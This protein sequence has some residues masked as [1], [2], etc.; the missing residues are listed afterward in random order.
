MTPEQK[1][2]AR[3]LNAAGISQA[4]ISRRL[5][6]SRRQVRSV[7]DQS[8]RFKKPPWITPDIEP[9]WR[10]EYR[11]AGEHAAAKLA[12]ERLAEMRAGK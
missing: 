7:V 5:N 10:R 2:E 4:E 12:R 8:P 9:I 3:A 11:Q 1:A 6:V